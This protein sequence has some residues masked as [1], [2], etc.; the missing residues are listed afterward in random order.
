MFSAGL[1][2]TNVYLSL[3]LPST[4]KSNMSSRETVYKKIKLNKKQ[5]LSTSIFIKEYETAFWGE[6]ISLDFL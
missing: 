4:E 1:K 5:P 2:T 3:V 6:E